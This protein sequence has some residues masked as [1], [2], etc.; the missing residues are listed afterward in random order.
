MLRPLL[1]QSIR[2]LGALALLAALAA[3]DQKPTPTAQAQ[4]PAASAA[5]VASTTAPAPLTPATATIPPPDVGKLETV[6]VTADGYGG[7]ASEAVAEAMSMAIMQ[8]NGAAVDMAT[9][10]AR[11]G[12]DVTTNQTSASMR[13][14]GFAEAVRTRSG[15][16]VQ[17]FRIV[18]MDEP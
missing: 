4:A 1:C 2:V 3:C 11:L 5:A 13:A 6:K 7:S 16:V 15:G 9:I 10:R 8:V 12:I 18:N 14:E 17:N